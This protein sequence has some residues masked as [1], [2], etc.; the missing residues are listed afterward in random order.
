MSYIVFSND[1]RCSD[2]LEFGGKAASLARLEALG[3]RVPSFAALSVEALRQYGDSEFSVKLTQEI[4]RAVD[5]LGGSGVALAVRSSAVDEDTVGSSFAGLYH[6]ELDVRGTDAVIDAIRKCWSSFSNE[7]AETYRRERGAVAEFNGMGVVLQQMVDAEWAGVC[8]TANPVNLALSEGVINSTR[9]LGEA[10]VSGSVNPEEITVDAD[11][12]G[13]IVR[14]KGADDSPLPE[15]HVRVVWQESARI[16]DELGFP[17]DTEWAVADDAVHFLQSRPITTVAGVFHNRVIEPWASSGGRPDDAARIWSR[18][19]ADEIWTPPVSPL[20]YNIQNLTPAIA[21]NLAW[22][23]D[24]RQLPPDIFKYFRASPY[25]DIDVLQRLYEYQPRF[26]RLPVLLQQFPASAQQRVALARFRVLGRAWRTLRFETRQRKVR[27]ISHT[28][29]CIKEQWPPFVERSD[30]WLDL[31]LSAMSIEELRAHFTEVGAAAGEVAPP[32]E[33]AVFFHATDLKL[34]LTAL[35][36]RW[37]GNGEERYASVSSGL[38]DSETVKE[39]DGIWAIASTLRKAGS[40]VVD[41]AVGSSWSQFRQWALDRSAADLVADFEV[42][43]RAHR[44]RGANY[45]DLIHP[46]WGD[47]PDLL[48]DAVKSHLRGQDLRRPL[49]LNAEV[50]ARRREEQAET[51]RAVSGTLAI[52]RRRLLEKLFR[53]NELYMSERDNHRYYFDRVWY[54]MRR[55]YVSYGERLAE[56]GVLDNA[57]DVFFLGAGEV[58]AALDRQLSE[59]VVKE[60]VCVRAAEWNQTRREQPPKFLVGYAPYSDGAPEADGSTM[61]GVGAS[62]G[63]A[64]GRARVVYDVHELASVEP[65]DILVTRQTDSGWTSGLSRIAGL[66]L[67]TGGILAHGASLCREYGVPCVTGLEG[68]TNR[69]HDG[70]TVRVSGTDGTVD[71]LTV[72]V[73]ARRG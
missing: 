20:F 17:Q 57:D 18:A 51:L 31:D 69:V 73:S 63:T 44:H 55:V 65:G 23:G 52:V 16:A 27:S 71:I 33:F 59:R 41:A 58:D 14:R 72:P 24:R 9:G 53:F 29:V 35:L 56:L 11:A 6:T 15:R 4:A 32:C 47:D 39:A 5:A 68:A 8:F 46:R 2:H 61:K 42:F 62:P 3:C 21:S 40:D 30:V 38:A 66:I 10:V 64:T 36:D 12:G 13:R 28:H 34:L 50:G 60:R 7:I 1:A 70:A 22:H 45:K 48:F 43:W 37:L 26:A 54:A 25:V 67:E 49:T 19:Y